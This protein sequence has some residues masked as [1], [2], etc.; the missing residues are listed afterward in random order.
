MVPRS[1][2]RARRVRFILQGDESF[3]YVVTA[4]SVEGDHAF[5]GTLR[6][7]DR[8][9]SDVGGDSVVTVAADATQ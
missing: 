2:S 9:S 7:E 4:S 3:T 5:E 1:G 8:G 6:D